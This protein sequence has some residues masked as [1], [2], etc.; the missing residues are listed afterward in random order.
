MSFAIAFLAGVAFLVGAV[1]IWGVP[2]DKL[3]SALTAAVILVGSLAVLALITVALIKM[4]RK[5]KD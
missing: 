3:W 5:N 4:L 2:A 1:K